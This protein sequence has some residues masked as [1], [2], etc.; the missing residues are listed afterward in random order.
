LATIK[1][2]NKPKISKMGVADFM[3]FLLRV[4]V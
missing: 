2:H 1:K 4:E 3:V